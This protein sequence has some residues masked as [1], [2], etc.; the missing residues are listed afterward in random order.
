MRNCTLCKSSNVHP[1]PAPGDKRS[2]YYCDTCFLIFAD[3]EY[4]LSLEDERS[5]YQTHNNGIEYPG[6]VQF[7]NRVISPALNYL[8]APMIGL[9]YGCGPSPT[10]SKIL[11]SHNLECYDYDPVFGFDHPNRIY[12]FLFATECLEHFFDPHKELEAIHRLVKKDGIVGIMTE[13]WTTK[14]HFANW[15]YKRDPTH[16]SFY[17]LNTFHFIARSLGFRIEFM[18][19]DRVIIL[20]KT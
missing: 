6:Y 15:Y 12:D 14:E 11:K 16:V 3:P 7:L 8:Q 13:R 2:Y 5:R 17:H 9:D 20:R 10:L 19:A 18:D 4:H 1:V